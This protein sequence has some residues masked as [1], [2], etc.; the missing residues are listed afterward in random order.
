MACSFS[1]LCQC[2]H[3]AAGPLASILV[4][5]VRKNQNNPLPLRS[6]DK[7]TASN[8]GLASDWPWAGLATLSWEKGR[9]PAS[10]QL[11]QLGGRDPGSLRGHGLRAMVT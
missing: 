3:L 10:R 8:A 1:Q 2:E 11:C 5:L 9:K 4:P 7:S 6:R